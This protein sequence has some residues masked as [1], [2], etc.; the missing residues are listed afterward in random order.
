MILLALAC[1]PMEEVELVP[2]APP[3]SEARAR[4][5][6]DL[7]DWAADERARFSVPPVA[8]F[9]PEGA[10]LRDGAPHPGVE[11]P[12]VEA[13]ED[14]LVLAEDVG[15]LRA[16]V[17][18]DPGAPDR[19]LYADT[20]VGVGG[21]RVEPGGAGILLRAGVAVRE[22]G[23]RTVVD[24]DGG[25]EGA[26]EVWAGDVEHRWLPGDPIGYDAGGDATLP[27]GT[28]LHDEAGDRLARLAAEAD[29]EVV[30]RAGDQALVEVVSAWSAT[31]ARARGWVAA[32]EVRPVGW[33]RFGGLCG[34]G[35]GGF[36]YGWGPDEP[37]VP[38]GT[39]VFDAPD[40]QPVG[41]VLRDQA[42]PIADPD[43]GGTVP[44]WTSLGSGE[45]WVP[46]A[47]R[48]GP[49]DAAFQ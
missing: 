18:V 37:V 17:E 21:A 39:L 41:V 9:G 29:V 7:G 49:P 43:A 19:V 6:L 8:R 4:A 30:A 46:P 28:W 3:V 5:L 47:E 42:L 10:A 13:R 36:G 38:A 33:G 2:E 40:G 27:G 11:L 45:V 31:W 15:W 1:G 35:V 14:A 16:L 12:V 44:A 32:S 23:P 24:L 22:E 25:L 34:C 48:W 26:A 20:W